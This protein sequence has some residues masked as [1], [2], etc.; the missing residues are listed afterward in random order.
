MIVHYEVQ[1][2]SDVDFATPQAWNLQWSG[3]SLNLALN[4]GSYVWRVRAVDSNG[5]IGPW[6]DTATF[7]VTDGVQHIDPFVGGGSRGES[8]LGSIANTPLS[9]ELGLLA[10]ILLAAGTLALRRP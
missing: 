2:D 9:A 5:N 10:L 7:Q 6:S 4:M 1:I 8:C 3:T